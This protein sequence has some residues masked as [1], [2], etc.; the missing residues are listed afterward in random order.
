MSTALS[1]IRVLCL[2]QQYPGPF[3]TMLL[4]DLG[5]DVVLVE[6][7]GVGDPTRAAPAF[8]AA[9]ARGKRSVALDLKTATGQELLA[10]L[11]R[12]ADVVLD[13]FRPATSKRLGV[14]A[15]SLRAIRP[16]LVHVAITG[17]G[18]TGPDLDRPGHDLTYQAEAGLLPLS[19][20]P[21]G[22]TWRP[23]ALDLGDLA[24]GLF[25]T[26]SV[27]LGLLRREREKTGSTLDVAMVDSLLALSTAYLVPA[28]NGAEPGFPREPGYGLFTTADGVRI[29]LG[30]AHEDHFWRGLCAATGLADFRELRAS[31]RVGRIG[32][33]R[34]RLV[35]EIGKQPAAHWTRMLRAHDVPFGLVR[36]AADITESAQLRARRMLVDGDGA[37]GLRWAV[38]Q[39]ILLDGAAGAIDTRVPRLGEHT[40]AVLREAGVP[41]D[42]I[43]AALAQGVATQAGTAKTTEDS[44]PTDTFRPGS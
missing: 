9:L 10:D 34:A 30:V 7:P 23:P 11:V 6:R 21:P 37:P 31:Q 39:P 29:A 25:A 2:A 20:P 14:D 24:A 40:V 19:G 27:L 18:L 13:G 17:F 38:R 8:H 5:A 15:A 12:H 26:I 42:R 16:D 3:A 33:L 35:A 44:H 41:E 36:S 28:L 4:S 1:G 32:E 43:S 22:D